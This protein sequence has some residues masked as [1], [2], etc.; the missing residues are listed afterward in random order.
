MFS[1]V[2]TWIND[3]VNNRE[4]GDLRRRRVYYD[5]TVMMCNLDDWDED[6]IRIL[7]MRDFLA[8]V[9]VFAWYE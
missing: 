8:Q 9:I 3:L 6:K 1:L 2:S 4:A 5:V 7:Y